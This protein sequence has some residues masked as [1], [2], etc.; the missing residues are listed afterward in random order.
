MFRMKSHD[1]L[2]NMIYNY[3]RFIFAKNTVNAY[4]MPQN[5]RVCFIYFQNNLNGGRRTPLTETSEA[6]EQIKVFTG[7]CLKILSFH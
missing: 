7:K 5:P 1:L 3:S 6:V 2:E 4:H